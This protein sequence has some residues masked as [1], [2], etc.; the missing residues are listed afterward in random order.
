MF[1]FLAPSGEREIDEKDLEDGFSV[2]DFC[3][4]NKFENH[5]GRRRRLSQFGIHATAVTTVS[6][7]TYE[8]KIKDKSIFKKITNRNRNV[9]KTAEYVSS[10]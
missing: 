1:A 10:S 8:L 7:H 6:K 2:R 5:V 3:P 9:E 4:A